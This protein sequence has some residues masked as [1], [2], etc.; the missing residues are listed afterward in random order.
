MGEEVMLD[1]RRTAE[2]QKLRPRCR[3]LAMRITWARVLQACREIEDFY[4]V[5]GS[6]ELAK[7]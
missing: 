7:S 1:S 5:Q 3:G 4:K 6:I 2:P